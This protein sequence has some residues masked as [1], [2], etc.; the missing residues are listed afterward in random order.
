MG[1]MSPYILSIIQSRRRETIRCGTHRKGRLWYLYN[2]QSKKVLKVRKQRL[3]NYGIF[4]IYFTLH[5]SIVLSFS[6]FT[7]S[8]DAWS[9]PLRLCLWWMRFTFASPLHQLV[10]SVFRQLHPPELY[11]LIFFNYI[12]VHNFQPVQFVRQPCFNSTQNSSTASPT[13]VHGSHPMSELHS[14]L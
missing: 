2:L 6:Y 11:N 13:Q 14:D 7:L 10:S 12:F 3:Y 5:N 4:F 9:P 8:N 1:H